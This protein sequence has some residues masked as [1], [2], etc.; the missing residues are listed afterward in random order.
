[1]K[2]IITMLA[3]VCVAAL[4]FAQNSSILRPRMEIAELETEVADMFDTRLEVF[5]MDDES[6]RMYYLSLGRLGMGT[7]I[8]QIDFDPLFELF[9]PLG[10]T[11]EEAIARMEEIKGY[12][13]LPKLSTAELSGSFA[14]AYPN[15]TLVTVTVTRRQLL[16]SRLLEFSIPTGTEGIVRATHISKSDF[17]SLLS[18][19]KFYKKIHP[20]EP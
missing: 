1:M 19:V 13:A 2:R 7:G 15:D 14:L 18:S 6:P 9:V 11:L 12:Y 20:N 5:Y 16:F 10:G 8:L 3:L 4:A 17:S